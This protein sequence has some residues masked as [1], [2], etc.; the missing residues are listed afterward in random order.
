MQHEHAD[1]DERGGGGGGRHDEDE[2]GDEQGQQHEHGDGEAGQAGAAADRDAGGALDI[3]DDRAG[4]A[5][6]AE[7]GGD[8]VGEEGAAGL[9]EVSVFIEKTR[10]FGDTDERAE[11][12][13]HVHQQQGQDEGQRLHQRGKVAQEGQ[14]ELQE[15]R[16]DGR[17]GGENRV[18]PR[19]DRAAP[20]VGQEE[21]DHRD[22]HDADEHRARHAARD[23]HGGEDDA[24]E[25]QRDR[26]GGEIPR[27][28]EGLGMGHDDARVFQADEGD[29]NTD[30]ARDGDLQGVGDGVDD[31]FPHPGEREHEEQHAVDEDH[32]ERLLPRHAGA[33]AD[34]E[35]E[36]G[37]DAH[38]RGEGDG[39]V[40]EQRHEHGGE[41]GGEGGGGE[42][43]ALD[44]DVGGG[45]GVGADGGIGREAVHQDGR[46]DRQDVGHG[47]ERGQAGGEFARDGGAV[48]GKFEEAGEH[49]RKRKAER[50]KN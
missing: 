14:V 32:A 39:V 37:V 27:G 20:A 18:G 28:D 23:Q 8:G 2:R 44:R 36:K 3:G 13:E 11:V 12:V 42:Q 22:D 43:G 9:R 47:G 5:E 6:R 24:R 30:A 29:E 21:A 41:R 25:G 4:A 33:E 46:V 15:N 40:G 38:A 50:P 35:G 34:G 45:G 31:F 10:A 17:R 26:R 7:D 16:D 1:D 19:G 49:G 48:L